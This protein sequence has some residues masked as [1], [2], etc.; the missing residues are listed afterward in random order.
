M[1]LVTHGHFDHSASAPDLLL[2]S[3]KDTAKICA[4]FEINLHFNKF[5]D[6]PEDRMEKMNSGGTIDFGFAKVMM[7]PADHSSS[8]MCPN[9]DIVNAGNP[10]GFVLSIPHLNARIYHAGDTNVFTDMGLINELGKPNILMIPIG[11]RFTMGAEGAAITCERFFPEARY[12]VP[13]HFGT[14]PLLTGTYDGFKSA[15]EKRNVD[16]NRL[17]NTPEYKDDGKDWKVDLEQL[18]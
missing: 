1:I 13:M 2:K 5:R 17:I 10:A 15:L 8:C 7:T 16:L 12:I 3:K 18:K 14:F 4:N 6:V 11:D 9:G